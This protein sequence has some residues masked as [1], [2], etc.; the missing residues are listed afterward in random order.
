MAKYANYM[1]HFKQKVVAFAGENGKRAARQE[2]EV[3]KKCVKTASLTE[4]CCW[5]LQAWCAIS[6]RMEEKSFQVMEIQSTLDVTKDDLISDRYED[7]MQ[8]S[9]EGNGTDKES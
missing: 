4:V 2:F 9:S 6:F 3:D 7:D 5:I 1:S 8:L